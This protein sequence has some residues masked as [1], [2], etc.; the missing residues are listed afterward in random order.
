VSSGD[1]S[2]EGTLINTRRKAAASR[3]GPYDWNAGL[4]QKGERRFL[5]A[6][7]KEKGRMAIVKT[8]RKIPTSSNRAML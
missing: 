4:L 8:I 1:P 5:A 7:S 3:G 2:G 6:R